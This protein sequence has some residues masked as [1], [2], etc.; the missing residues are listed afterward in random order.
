MGLSENPDFGRRVFF[1]NPPYAIK[2][3]V[4]ERLQSQEYEAFY[5]EDY[6]NAKP[7]LQKYRDSICFI[8]IDDGLTIKEWFNFVKSFESDHVLST[9]YLG[10]LSQKAKLSEKNE[11]ILKT[12]IPGGFIMLDE[13]LE[14]ISDKITKIC[15]LNGAKGRR[16]YV[17]L[18]CKNLKDA[19]VHISKDGHLY[20]FKLID[21]SSVGFACA[22]SPHE[23]TK[24]KDK[25]ILRSV[26]ISIGSKT[27]NCEAAIFAIKP[28]NPSSTIVMLLMPTTPVSTKNLIRKYVFA[29]MQAEIKGLEDCSIADMTD[30]SKEKKEDIISNTTFI[31]DLSGDG[32]GCFADL[33]ELE[34]I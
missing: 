23:S 25:E 5:I 16:Q 15:E 13:G 33:E 17:R 34:E 10:I 3:T 32:I 6:H 29:N 24:F 20:T 8:N 18:N 12:N 14:K 30:Y 31:T 9:I 21:I 7:V 2:T 1:L 19:T 28:G 22:V 4:V 11:F 27:I 26:V